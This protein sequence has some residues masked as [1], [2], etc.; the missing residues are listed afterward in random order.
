MTRRVLAG[1]AVAALSVV[2]AG[3]S[4]PPPVASNAVPNAVQPDAAPIVWAA[5]GGDETRATDQKTLPGAWTQQVLSR[6]AP[7]AQLL[8]VATE[9]ATVRTGLTSQLGALAASP[10]KPTVATVWFGSADPTTPKAQFAQDLTTLVENLRAQ[11]VARIV[12]VA[13]PDGPGDRGYRFSS[14]IRAVAA[15]TGATFVQV[16]TLTTN[17]GD[18]AAQTAIAEQLAPAI[19]G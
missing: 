5:L 9:D 7:S 18:P 11:G 8:D 10:A 14:E 6:L 16:S 13:R 17:P 15:A 2:G 4:S 1:L 19:T 3:C 12:L